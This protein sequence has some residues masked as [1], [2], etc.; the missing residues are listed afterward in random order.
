[1]SER[2]RQKKRISAVSMQHY[3]RLVYRSILLLVSLGIYLYNRI[4]HTGRVLGGMDE[5]P[6]IL[7]VLWLVFAVEMVM[8]MFPNKTES[9]GCQKQFAR[10]YRQRKDAPMPAKLNTAHTT[11]AVFGAW[12]GLNGIIGI[13]YF[14]GIIDKGI[15]L[16]ICMAYSVCD[17]VCILY[18]CP[19][20]SWFMKNKCCGTCR[21][22]NWDYAMMF[23]P[24]FF[25]PKTY[26]W[27]LLV[28]SLGLMARWE[29]TFY[30][31][32]ERFSENT[33]GYLKCKNC[34]EK[35]CTHKTQLKTLWEEID[36]YYA[37]RITRLK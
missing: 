30:R 6:I 23:T 32:P 15:L 19:F 13:L 22:Y 27:S 7:S 33:N 21:I 36:R 12:V 31:H 18:F 20:Q 3:F 11:L 10:N 28:L 16:L 24:L 34:T 2:R 5:N 4:L 25:I 9:M 29:I 8:R 26:T 37:E 17:M 14:T 1:M 35:L